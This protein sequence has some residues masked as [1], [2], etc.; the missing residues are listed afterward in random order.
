MRTVEPK[1]AAA[2][3]D[4]M[5]VVDFLGLVGDAA[6]DDGGALDARTPT[7]DALCDRLQERM[8]YAEG[9]RDMVLLHH[10]FE[11]T[12]ADGRR[13]ALT[14]TLQMYG[15]PA[16]DT[17]MATTVGVTTGIGAALVLSGAIADPGVCIPTASS[18]YEPMLRELERCGIRCVERSSDLSEHY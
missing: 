9:E 4:V 8:Q 18:I 5:R 2:I 11:V 17:A 14:S 10:E 6:N 13:E 7:I 15:V 16:G 12:R 1:G 3:E